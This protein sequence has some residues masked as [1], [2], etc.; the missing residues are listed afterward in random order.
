MSRWHVPYKLPP[1][2]AFG[3]LVLG[4][5]VIASSLVAISM[6]LYF[7][8]GTAQ[9]DMSRPSLQAVRNKAQQTERFEGFTADGPLDK[10]SLDEFEKLY[11]T[12]AKEVQRSTK[13]FFPE[14][15]TDATLGIRVE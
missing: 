7:R 12:K 8:S 6:G 13:E 4:A 11:D 2:V 10:K 14:D 1:H 15:M 9:L 3:L 5:I